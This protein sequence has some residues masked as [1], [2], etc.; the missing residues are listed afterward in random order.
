MAAKLGGHLTHK[1]SAESKGG[2]VESGMNQGDA[3][4]ALAGLFG[5]KKTPTKKPSPSSGG[6]G[7][8]SGPSQAGAVAALG[9]LFAK[10]QNPPKSTGSSSTSKSG[11]GGGGGGDAS[12]YKQIFKKYEM[13]MKLGIN[14]HGAVGRMR[15]DG[16]GKDVIAAFEKKHGGLWLDIISKI[17]FFYDLKC[18]IFYDLILCP[19]E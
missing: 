5:A 2:G 16:I 8:D 9:G 19:F 13:M 1:K 12:K 6:G 4:N 18:Y 15:Q 10:K 7:V 11:G 3:K 14:V 17:H